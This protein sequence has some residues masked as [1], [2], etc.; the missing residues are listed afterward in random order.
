MKCE[1]LWETYAQTQTHVYTTKFTT[2]KKN[3]IGVLQFTVQS[4]QNPTPTLNSNS[5]PAGI[6]IP[7]ETLCKTHLPSHELREGTLP[8]CPSFLSTKDWLY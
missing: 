3:N 7:A 6:F 2:L 4:V 8:L 1:S 5:N